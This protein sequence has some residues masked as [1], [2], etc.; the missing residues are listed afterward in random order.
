MALSNNAGQ[1]ATSP[2][3]TTTTVD[4]IPE[5]ML[6]CQV[7]K[8]NAPYEI[9]EVPTPRTLQPYDLLLKTAVASLCHTDSMVQ[10]GVM[11]SK[12]PMTASHEPTGTVVAT[13]SAVTDFQKGDRVLP[14]IMYDRCGHCIDCLGPEDYRQYCPNNGGAV[15]V[16]ID[17]AFAEY[18]VVDAREA[19]KLPDNLSFLSAAPLA[20]AGC[21]VFRGVLQAG[22]VKG[23]WIGI[24]G[25][26]GGLGHLGVQ[27]AK[28]LGLHVVG[29]DARDE[30]LELSK[31]AGADVLVDAR[32][33]KETVVQRVQSVTGGAGVDATVNVSDASSAAGLACAITK[34]HGAMVQ[35]AQ[36]TEVSI[37]F[38][39]LIFRDIRVKGSLISSRAEAQRMLALTVEHGI[40]V[41]KNVFRGLRA[42]PELVDLAHGGKM[43]GKGVVVIDEEA[44]GREEGREGML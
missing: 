3:M 8:F 39:E 9:R 30:G 15:G 38:A 42:I 26:G 12:L 24:V 2:T 10:A 34:M 33:E 5:S 11:G 13:G 23:E 21:T 16:Q 36:P 31:Q 1:T 27:F 35:I 17:G 18:I 29:V 44:V 25:S 32:V 22:L 6:A 4:D 37:P 7:V 14:G 28:A 19:S 20:C 40:T 41:E 43:K